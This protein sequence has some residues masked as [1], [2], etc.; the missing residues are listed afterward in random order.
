MTAPLLLALG[1][2]AVQAEGGAA[3]PP[4]QIR[5][6]VWRPQPPARGLAAEIDALVSGSADARWIGWSAPAA[7]RAAM[8]CFELA[9]GV[10]RGGCCALEEREA[11]R[12]V[13]TGEAPVRALE[14]PPTVRVLLRAERGR[15]GRVRAFSSDCLLD[16]GGRALHWLG[17]AGSGES[18]AALSRLLGAGAGDADD[19]LSAL[20]ALAGPEADAALE[21]FARR[22]PDRKL[23]G[24]ALFW[25]AQRA[26]DK[27]AGS[28]ARAVREDP[29]AEVRKQAV[30][31]LSELPDGA[32]IPH[33][34]QVARA[35]RDPEVRRAAFYWLGES[36]DPRA[37]D[38]LAEVLRRSGPE[39]RP[40]RSRRDRP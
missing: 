24:Q 17:A 3:Q 33:L 30:F 25:M 1:V 23:R 38:F 32:G 39:P 4:E 8:C 28:I 15:V 21:G 2:A 35:H 27:A 34:M 36:E 11:G 16:F 22:D 5:R 7:E 29:D 19:V 31:A 12:V 13:G 10:P 20:A 18:V 6:A 14:A 40:D 9:R 37:L 26:A